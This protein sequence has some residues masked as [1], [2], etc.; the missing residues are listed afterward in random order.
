MVLTV[1]M[2]CSVLSGLPGLDFPPEYQPPPEELHTP[3]T[4]VSLSAYLSFSDCNIP[5]QSYLVALMVLID[6]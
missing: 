5:S 4:T 2:R 3:A 1:M 6:F